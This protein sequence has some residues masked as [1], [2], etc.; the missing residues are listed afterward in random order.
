MQNRFRKI[1][2]LT[3]RSPSQPTTRGLYRPPPAGQNQPRMNTATAT[4][5]T[6]KSVARAVNTPTSLG[7]SRLKCTLIAIA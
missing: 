1:R 5:S 6:A 4:L 2:T 3:M 7:A